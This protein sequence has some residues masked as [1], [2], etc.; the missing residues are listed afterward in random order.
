VE[1]VQRNNVQSTK[2]IRDGMVYVLRNGKLYSILGQN[3]K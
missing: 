1:D 3:V 2:V